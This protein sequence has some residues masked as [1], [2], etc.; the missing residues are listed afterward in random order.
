[1]N[2]HKIKLQDTG[3]IVSA[4]AGMSLIQVLRKA[5]V[6]I[7][8]S[9]GGKGKCGTCKVRVLERDTLFKTDGILTDSEETLLTDEEKTGLI[10]LACQKKVDHDMVVSLIDSPDILHT[11]T[12]LDVE[13]MQ[14]TNPG[15]CKR[16]LEIE[17]SDYQD[18]SDSEQV[19]KAL[20]NS[21][22]D[23]LDRLQERTAPEILA[24]CAE[25]LA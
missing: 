8:C 12:E 10:R 3:E 23:T 20:G 18:I 13:K 15:V 5:G 6:D 16:F 1:M 21:R 19:L 25:G 7:E 22:H 4:R 2:Y 14:K 17:P 24:C 11:V 9:C